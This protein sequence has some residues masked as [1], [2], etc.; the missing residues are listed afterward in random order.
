MAGKRKRFNNDPKGGK[1]RRSEWESNQNE[2]RHEGSYKLEDIQNSDEYTVRIT[3]VNPVK[4]KYALCISYLGSEYQGLQINPGAKTVEAELEKALYLSGTVAEANFGYMQ[5]V[6]W[7]R[8]ARTDRGVHAMTQCCAM[9]LSF[10]YDQ[11]SLVRDQI[12]QFLPADIRIQAITKVAKNFNAHAQCTKRNYNY[13][14]P[15]YMLQDFDT[16]NTALA[17][18]F[19]EQGPIKGA[20]YEGGYVDPSSSKFLN[21]EYLKKARDSIVQYRIDAERLNRFRSALKEYEGT[22]SYHNFTVGK[23]ATEA[24]A[25]RYI[26][27]FD[28]SEPFIAHNTGIEWVLLSVFGQSFLL[29][30][31]RKMVGFAVDVCR[32]QGTLEQMQESFTHV[33]VRSNMIILLYLL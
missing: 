33:K 3:Q 25:K 30:Q 12:N 6:Q 26:I 4:K 9:K 16:V 8:A 17:T 24:N 7:T 15:T 10:P 28:C 23:D 19:A 5:K 20:G 29:N 2:E 14:L 21:G 27:S 11:R 32:G 1:W 18:V 22:K 13:L 31:I